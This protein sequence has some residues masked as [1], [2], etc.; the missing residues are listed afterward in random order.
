MFLENLRF[1]Q[2]SGN[3]AN[4]WERGEGW[5]RGRLGHVLCVITTQCILKSICDSLLNPKH[6]RVIYPWGLLNVLKSSYILFS[7]EGEDVG[8]F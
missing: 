5:V 4:K 2:K 1:C 3:D 7:Y 8:I 6:S